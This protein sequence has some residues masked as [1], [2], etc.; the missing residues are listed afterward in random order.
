MHASCTGQIVIFTN[1]P[2]S[3]APLCLWPSFLS[4]AARA[5]LLIILAGRKR[6]VGQNHTYTCIYGV[7]KAFQAGESPYM[8]SFTVCIHGSGQPY[9]KQQ[10]V[11]TARLYTLN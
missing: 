5:I 2:S 3:N 9:N 1:Y 4:Q 10:T 7:H 6:R 8:Q 11:H